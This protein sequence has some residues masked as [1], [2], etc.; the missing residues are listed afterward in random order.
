MSSNCDD[1]NDSITDTTNITPFVS[2]YLKSNQKDMTPYV[3]VMFHDG[4]INDIEPNL[5]DITKFITVYLLEI[6]GQKID[7]FTP[8]ITDTVVVK[9]NENSLPKIRKKIDIKTARENGGYSGFDPEKYII[10]KMQKVYYLFNII[11]EYRIQTMINKRLA[12]RKDES[13]VQY[14]K[15]KENITNEVNEMYDKIECL[16]IDT[17]DEIDLKDIGP[18]YGSLHS[19]ITPLQTITNSCMPVE[20]KIHESL[21]FIQNYLQYMLKYEQR[22]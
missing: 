17:I 14:E 7:G 1:N 20:K 4:H 13:V 5:P 18:L 10:H 6:N 21:S 12:D 11:K 3:K 8:D 16:N 2:V 22:G 9:M 15:R 19:L